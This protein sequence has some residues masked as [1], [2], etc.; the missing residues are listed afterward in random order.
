MHY[1]FVITFKRSLKRNT[2][3]WKIVVWTNGIRGG[4]DF[5]FFNLW[6]KNVNN[7]FKEQRKLVFLHLVDDLPNN[8]FLRSCRITKKITILHCNNNNN[9]KFCVNRFH[10]LNSI[11]RIYDNKT[12]SN[13]FNNN[14]VWFRRAKQAITA[15]YYPS[16]RNLWILT[17]NT[18]L[19]WE[20]YSRED[21]MQKQ[22]CFPS[23][24]VPTSMFEE[25]N[26]FC[27]P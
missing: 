17:L 2:W 7:F 4:P 26:S 6:F 22:T 14:I 27:F 16:P 21:P 1:K 3:C 11:F 23:I 8:P 5:L 24:K 15:S 19:W 18:I 25:L 10:V 9:K 13:Q 12:R 20:T